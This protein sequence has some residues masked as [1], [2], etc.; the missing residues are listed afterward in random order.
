MDWGV[1]DYL[2][3]RKKILDCHTKDIICKSIILKNTAFD[4]SIKNELYQEYYLVIVQYVNEFNAEKIAKIL[5]HYINENYNLKLANK[6]FHFRLAYNDVAYE[7]TGFAFN[8]IG[9]YLMKC[10]DLKIIFPE[11]LYNI[12][13]RYFFL[14]GGD[15]LLKVGICMNDFL[16]LYGPN[17]II[18]DSTPDK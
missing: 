18:L 4:P 8:G 15:P 3:E 6:N 1:C 10:K 12:Y 2:D 11:S 7:M 13:P 9:P 17:T 16:K 5:K 14:G